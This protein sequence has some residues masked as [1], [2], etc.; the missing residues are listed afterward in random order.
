METLV[1]LVDAVAMVLLVL[2]SL[3]AAKAKPGEKFGGLFAYTVEV[4]TRDHKTNLPPAPY[5][6]NQPEQAVAPSGYQP[7]RS[8]SRRNKDNL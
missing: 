2:A 1:F 6:Q 4:S 5:L 8:R 7:G 3:S